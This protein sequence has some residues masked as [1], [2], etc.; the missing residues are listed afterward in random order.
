VRSTKSHAA[1]LVTLCVLVV[2]GVY[3][4]SAVSY[5]KPLAPNHAPLYGNFQNPIA[6]GLLHHQ[7]SLTVEPQEGLLRLPDPY[8]PIAND[9]YRAQGIHDFS[10]Y[11]GKFYAYFGPAPAILLYI[12]FRIF[13]VGDL[14]PTIATLVFATLGFLFSLALFRL[15]VRWCCGD[16]PVWMHCVAVF[17]LGLGVPVAWIVYIGRDYESSIACGYMLLFA[18]LYCVVRGGVTGT[19][20]LSLGLGSAAFGLAIAARPSLAVA[21]LFLVVTGL[22][23]RA[24]HSGRRLALLLLAL[25]APYVALGVLVALFNYARFGSITEFGQSYQLS[26]VNV[27]KYPFGSFSYIPKGLFAYFVSPAR[28][29]DDFPY[30][31]LRKQ[32]FDPVLVAQGPG[33]HMYLS[34]PVAG[35]VTNMPVVG[36]GFV[37]LLT[38]LRRVG[39]CFPRT[40]PTLLVL[41]VP[42]MFLVVVVS[43]QFQGATMRYELD[44]APLIVLASL[45]AW[46]AWYR[47]ARGR[48]WVTW[49]GNGLWIAAL[50]ASIVFNLAIT[51]TPCVGTGSC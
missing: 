23:L 24:R 33:L 12:P 10:L 36:I 31:F 25:V 37:L 47:A 50:L 48:A 29:L 15:L 27:P 3:A 39:R 17:T 28:V 41:V 9:P 2:L 4:R 42:A 30:L 22:I 14:S 51:S 11:K 5:G 7:L 19:S 43:Y 8:D 21:A 20:P 35:L 40:I 16:I 49:L 44:F 6:D 1:V 38:R 26:L 32:E 46:I 18:G 45:L 13:R 34:E